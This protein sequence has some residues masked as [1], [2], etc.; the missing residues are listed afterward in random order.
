MFALGSRCSNQAE[1]VSHCRWLGSNACC[2]KHTTS[3]QNWHELTM[4]GWGQGGCWNL[5]CAW[6]P[7]LP[8]GT[9]WTRHTLR[10]CQQI[11]TDTRIFYDICCQFYIAGTWQSLMC[12]RKHVFSGAV[13]DFI[14]SR[15]PRHGRQ[16]DLGWGTCKWQIIETVERLEPEC[17]I[18]IG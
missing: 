16:L 10:Y 14:T 3:Q 2:G 15:A 18:H 12:L 6:I 5:C 13:W 17:K 8:K 11:I 9:V 7:S 1:D 4:I